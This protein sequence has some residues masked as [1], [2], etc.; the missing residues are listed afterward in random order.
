MKKT[1]KT[2]FFEN[3]KKH[4]KLTFFWGLQK[5]EIRPKFGQNSRFSTKNWGFREP[6]N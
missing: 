6:Q 4:Q 5:P 2:E 3:P 1:R